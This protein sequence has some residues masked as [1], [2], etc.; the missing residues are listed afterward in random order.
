MP[1]KYPCKRIDLLFGI[2]IT[3]RAVLLNKGRSESCFEYLDGSPLRL[4]FLISLS[5]ACIVL[6]QAF[7][8]SLRSF[9]EIKSLQSVK[10]DCIIFPTLMSLLRG[11]VSLSSF[12]MISCFGTHKRTSSRPRR[13][14]DFVGISSNSLGINFI[15]LAPNHTQAVFDVNGVLKPQRRTVKSLPVLNVKSS[16]DDCCKYLGAARAVCS[17]QY[18]LLVKFASGHWVF[19]CL[20]NV[21]IPFLSLLDWKWN[22]NLLATTTAKSSVA[23]E[24]SIPIKNDRGGGPQCFHNFE[25]VYFYSSQQAVAHSIPCSWRGRPC[26]LE[27]EF[28]WLG[29]PR[30]VL[31]YSKP[32][33][34]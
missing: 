21:S 4:T 8:A 32:T 2:T 31:C 16:K 20:I 28:L 26:G 15:V 33:G 11:A 12:W 6:W 23:F 30:W 17:M 24:M 7:F 25:W 27:P 19:N 29:P 10:G 9:L 13:R 5:S 3:I 34:T 18:K 14:S 1:P 22:S